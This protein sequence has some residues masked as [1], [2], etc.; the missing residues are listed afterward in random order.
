MKRKTA[1]CTALSLL[2][3]LALATAAFARYNVTRECTP[4]LTFSGTTATA[5][6]VVKAQA[7]ASIEADLTLYRLNGSRQIE[8]A[9]W[10]ESGATSLAFSDTVSCSR[11]YDYLLEVDVTV[12][13]DSGS[14][15]ITKSASADSSWVWGISTL[16]SRAS[17]SSWA[18]LPFSTRFCRDLDSSSLWRWA[19]AGEL[20]YIRTV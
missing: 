16:A 13:G 12:V 14:D 4:R 3:A 15:Y 6:L 1:R 10:S 20:A 18:I 8:V 19:E 11:G 17:L 2:L 5:S 7:G 9:S